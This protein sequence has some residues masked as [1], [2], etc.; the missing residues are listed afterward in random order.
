MVTGQRMVTQTQADFKRSSF[1]QHTWT[2]KDV[3]HVVHVL[4]R[5]KPMNSAQQ[6]SVLPM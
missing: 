1:M 2:G 4:M 3:A 6:G 5:M